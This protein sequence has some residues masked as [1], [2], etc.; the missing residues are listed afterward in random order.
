MQGGEHDVVKLL[1]F[2]LVKELAVDVGVALSQA[3]H[4]S[5]A[6]PHYMAPEAIRDPQTPST[7]APTSTRS[8]PSPTACSRARARVRGPHRS[9]EV[10]QPPSPQ[11]A[12]PAVRERRGVAVPR[13]SRPSSSQ[14]LAKTPD[15][16][17]SSAAVLRKQLAACADLGGW[18][19]EDARA[20]WD[21]HAAQVQARRTVADE[22]SGAKTI[23]VALHVLGRS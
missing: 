3:Q 14:C 23:D 20:W 13:T 8:A 15:G 16:R 4:T 22:I 9:I 21:R 1:D 7:R 2:G 10:L 5:P 17:P 19:L 6:R 12:R 18:D 11:E